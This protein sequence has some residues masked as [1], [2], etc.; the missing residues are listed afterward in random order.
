MDS[1]A[2]P[3]FSNEWELR[4]MTTFFLKLTAV[5]LMTLDHL[6]LYFPAAPVWFRW[7]GRGPIPCSSSA[8]FRAMPTL[9]AGGGIFCGS[10]Y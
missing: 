5:V 3:P 2:E 6:G 9:G 10:I 4:S 1:G 7:L 8:W